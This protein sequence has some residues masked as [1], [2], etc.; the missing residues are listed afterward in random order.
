MDIGLIV[1]SAFIIAIVVLIL[2]F[3]NKY[4]NFMDSLVKKIID[5]FSNLSFVIIGCL[6]LILALFLIAFLF[7]RS[8]KYYS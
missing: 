8:K 1:L 6:A 7:A 3:I 5:S 2:F 4:E